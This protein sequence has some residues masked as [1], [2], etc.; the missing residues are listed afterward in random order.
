MIVRM[1]DGTAARIVYFGDVPPRVVIAPA[2]I[3]AG[4]PLF[5]SSVGITSSFVDLQRMAAMMEREVD[6]IMRQATAA[7]E[8][9]LRSLAA[10]SAA[11]RSTSSPLSR[12]GLCVR[13][14]EVTDDGTGVAHVV[15]RST[16]DCGL[17]RP[18]GTPATTTIP[19]RIAPA[20]Q[21]RPRLIEVKADDNR[22]LLAMAQPADAER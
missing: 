17:A 8:A 1:P 18:G 13:T 3:F 10:D 7:Q 12:S 9:A 16:R 11:A 6:L 20:H 14:F 15:S 5:D 22:P 4:S 2:P 21:T 19:K